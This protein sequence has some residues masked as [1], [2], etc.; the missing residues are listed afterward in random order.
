MKRPIA[1][2]LMMICLLAWSGVT[3]QN[4]PVLMRVGDDIVTQN[5]FV[6][7]FTK[8]NSLSNATEKELR[9]YLDLY[10]NFRLKVQEGKALGVDTSD[11]FKSELAV[12]RNQSSQPYLIDKDVNDKL[13][14]EAYERSKY[15]IRASHILINCR[16]NTDAKDTLQAY[17]RA[18]DI[19]NKVL[20][21]MDFAEAAVLYSEDPSARNSVNEHTHQV[22]LG[23]KG[24]LGYFTALDLIY[25]FENAVYSLK[26]GEISMPVRTQFGYHL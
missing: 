26:V 20:N 17:N 14:E 16:P 3:A 5:E 22:R 24:D 13:I 10:V 12:Y 18:L 2:L 4:N 15:N 25:R 19:R 6:R 11:Q 1:F 9:D 21:G 23:N 7:A 8:N